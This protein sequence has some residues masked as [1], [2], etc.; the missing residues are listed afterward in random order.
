MS[1]L[2][3][4]WRTGKSDSY[5]GQI[6]LIDNDGNRVG[7][8]DCEDDDEEDANKKAGRIIACVNA[9]E[10]L[11]PEG[12]PGL[13]KMAERLYVQVIELTEQ[14]AGVAG[15]H[16]NGDLANW[17]WLMEDWL[18]DLYEL[19]DALAAVKEGK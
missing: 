7:W 5:T 11:D 17:D 14:S 10:G 4:P 3:T 12:I 1:D 2:K 13:V 18:S 6:E 9:C 8:L 16:L 19:R 15:L